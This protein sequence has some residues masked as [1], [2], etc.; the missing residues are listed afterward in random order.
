VADIKSIDASRPVV[1]GSDSYRSPPSPGS[2]NGRIALL[3]DGVG[4]NYN[5]AQSVD[6][7]HA[8]YPGKFIFESESSSSTSSRGNYQWPQ[9]LNTGEDYTPGHRLLSSYDNNMASWTMPGE[10]G[11]KKD[12]DRQ[13]FTGEFLWSGF[14]YIGE[15][16]PYNQ[17]PVKSSFFGAVDT[18]GFPKDL[19]YAFAS[20]WTTS[21][22]VHLVPMNWTDHAPGESVVVWAYANVEAVELF[23]NGVSLGVRRYDHKTTTF[24]APY[25]ETTEGTGDDKTFASRSYTSPN[26]S[27]GKLHLTWSVPFAPG[28]LLAV[29]TRNGAE[30]ARDVL[31]TAGAPHALRLTANRNVIIADRRALSYITVEVV[32]QSGIVVPSAHDVIHFDVKGGVLAGVDSGR[33]ESAEPYQAH[34][35]AAFN[36][37]VLAIVRSDGRV[38]SIAITASADGL[39]PDS[40]TVFEMPNLDAIVTT[41]GSPAGPLGIIEPR[42][43]APVGT[44]PVLP[45][46]VTVALSDGTTSQQPVTWSAVTKDQLASDRPYLVAGKVASAAPGSDGQV[47]AVVTPFTIARVE[48]FV[49]SVP[50]GVAPFLTAQARVT[51]GD[52]VSEE[53]DVEWE[54][55]SP[56]AL[57][58][59]GELSVRGRLVGTGLVTS[60]AVT[61]SE[62]FTAQ[63]NLAPEAVPS[64]SFSGAP[65]T[66]PASLNN[67]VTVDPGG[68]SNQYV[69]AATALLPA[70]SLAQPSD[71]VSL[72]WMTPQPLDTL[73]AYFHLAS[74][75]PLPAAVS[76]EYWDSQRF[77]PAANQ[78]VTWATASDQP[79]T[80]RFDKVSTTQVR[81]V[82]TSAA[83][84]TSTGFVQISELQALGDRSTA[85]TSPVQAIEREHGSD[86]ASGEAASGGCAIG[87][88][89]SVALLIGVMAI[90]YCALRGWRAARR[91]RGGGTP[92]RGSNP[93]D[94]DREKSVHPPG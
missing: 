42:V 6:A 33:Q 30:V 89:S 82:L 29:A 8:L 57:S 37:K 74:G 86:V 59:P 90:L 4:L 91:D 32:D 46:I 1:W 69:K 11:L 71:W 88:T 60:T 41:N 56:A 94:T 40:T 26:G 25:L 24:G 3:L 66:V 22:M 45:G 61:V 16:T 23:L 79:T 83:P 53:R 38:G 70:F 43:R 13:F 15:P 55:L 47:T 87:G 78:A 12:R 63:Q 67:G 80:I 48:S 64:A 21:P 68:W 65:T 34:D 10:Y 44:A 54:P 84:G 19:F 85:A 18:A 27:T 77:A 50:V 72:T 7:L 92:R 75:R 2:V 51:Y 39:V 31:R 93:Q 52:G 73:V 81:L 17:F 28:E 14:D 5:T 49:T 9:Q 58:A 36:G 20:Q 62:A 76:V 35:R